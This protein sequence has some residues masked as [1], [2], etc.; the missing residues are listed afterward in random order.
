[1]RLSKKKLFVVAIAVC[2][3]ATLSFG[4]L[5]WFTDTDRVDNQFNVTTSNE[6][7]DPDFSIVLFETEVDPETNGFGDGPDNN[8]TTDEVKENTYNHIAPGATL[9]KDPTVRNTGSY[10]QW[11]R[12]KVTFTDVAL[13]KSVM[14]D[15]YNFTAM[16]QNVSADWTL[17]ATTV[18]DTNADTI[19]YTYYYNNKLVANA[20]AT[21]FTGVKIPG[22]F[23]V[24]NMFDTFEIDLVAEA[25]QADNTG[26]TAPEA[27]TLWN[28]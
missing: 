18:S 27:F 4:T 7:G 23:K 1:M 17:D 16:L 13:W 19:T 24:E 2:L 11:V 9:P 21:L 14:G 25:T 5:A 8:T 28:N 20:E 10:D 26:D 15:N 3:V 6:T 22:D 12:V